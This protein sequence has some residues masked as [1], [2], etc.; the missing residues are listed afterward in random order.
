[1]GDFTACV[2]AEFK[3]TFE[4]MQQF[5]KSE[6]GQICDTRHEDKYNGTPGGKL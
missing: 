2:K 5:V 6:G 4:D 1:M 3:T